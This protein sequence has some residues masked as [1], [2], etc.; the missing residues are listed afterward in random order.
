[1]T[2]NSNF[3]EAA[4]LDS[5]GGRSS[6]DVKY[7]RNG[8]Y[9]LLDTKRGIIEKVY[10]PPTETIEKIMKHSEHSLAIS[11][12]LKKRYVPSMGNSKRR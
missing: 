4:W 5:R 1:M 3:W 12:A 10:I 11:T 2:G 9:I 8:K 7:D 6:K